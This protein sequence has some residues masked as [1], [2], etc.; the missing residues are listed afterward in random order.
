MSQQLPQDFSFPDPRQEPERS[1]QPRMKPGAR[2]AMWT[3]LLLTAVAAIL[4]AGVFRIRRIAVIGNS[5]V[6]WNE[7]VEAAGLE[8]GISYFAVNEEQIRANVERNRYLILEKLEKEFP[9]G[10]TLYVRERTVCANVKVMGVAYLL[11]EEGVVLERPADN[12]LMDNVPVITGL[13][14]R[15]VR[16]GKVIVPNTARQLAAYTGL[17]GELIR[18]GYLG[19]VSE[20]NLADPDSLYMITRN[21]YTV[22]LGNDEELR[23]KIGTVRGVVAKLLQMQKTGGVIEASTPAVATY[24]PA[25][26]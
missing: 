10:L 17:V 6:T 11:D 15:E 19:E 18:Q 7:V 3:F 25:E 2:T 16:L 13:Q 21:G 22:H 1:G 12:Q 4:Y 5:R 8:N 24:T 20:L 9:S 23:A 14:A 26:L